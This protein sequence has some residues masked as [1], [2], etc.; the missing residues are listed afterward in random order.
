[1]L[2]DRARHRPVQANRIDRDAPPVLDV[3]D[4]SHAY[5]GARRG[6]RRT[7]SAV[8]LDEVGFRVQPGETVGVIGES[9]AGKTSLL[10]VVLG[11]QRPDRGTVLLGGIDV[12]RAR[13]DALRDIRRGMQAVFQDPAGS[14]DPRQRIETIVAEPLHLLPIRPDPAARRATVEAVLAQVGLGP[15]AADRYPHQFSGGQRQRIGIARALIL[16]PPLVVLDEAVSALDVSVRADILDL[17]RRLSAERGLAFLFVSHDL[18]VMR[19]IAD[20]LIVMKD[21][22]IVEQGTTAD[23]LAAPTAPYTR[24][25]IDATPDLNRVVSERATAPE[26][27][28]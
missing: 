21:G 5:R 27:G 18:G 2:L 22:R 17:L 3:R 11:L 1:M 8:A 19:A 16:D 14:F 20:R 25:L 7:A 24:A 15:A 13:G 23:L 10:R 6:W 9:G 28:L 4:L 26:A 12:H